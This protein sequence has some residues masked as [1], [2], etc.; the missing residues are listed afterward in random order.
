MHTSQGGFAKR[1]ILQTRALFL[2]YDMYSDL[3]ESNTRQMIRASSQGVCLDRFDL[4]VLGT[5]RRIPAILSMYLYTMGKGFEVAILICSGLASPM[6]TSGSKQACTCVHSVSRES[7]TT[8]LTVDTTDLWRQ[9]RILKR[10]SPPLFYRDY[11]VTCMASVCTNGNSHSHSHSYSH[12][13][14]RLGSAPAV[15]N[16]ATSLEL[17]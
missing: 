14:L 1:P 2:T 9:I 6:E 8:I 17:N 4:L 15:P 12:S 13:L 5:N 11:G 16:S 7:A 10:P 3:K